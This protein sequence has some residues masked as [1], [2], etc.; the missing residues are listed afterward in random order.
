M[1]TG[2]LYLEDI[3]DL[4]RCHRFDLDKKLTDSFRHC[5]PYPLLPLLSLLPGIAGPNLCRYI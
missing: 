3:A 1:I 5:S 2:F 4:V